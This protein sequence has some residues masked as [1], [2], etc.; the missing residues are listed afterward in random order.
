MVE[1]TIAAVI[2][3]EIPDTNGLSALERDR[4]EGDVL[5]FVVARVK[6]MA[7]F[8]RTPMIILIVFFELSSFMIYLKRFST[9][10]IP[11]RR[12]HITKT[13][14]WPLTPFNSLLKAIRSL[15]L[16]AYYDHPAVRKVID[17]DWPW[18]DLERMLSDR[19]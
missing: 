1:K 13:E 18:S 11:D 2:E 15:M 4:V 16:L 19:E 14:R 6:A 8:L 17:Y 12:V 5:N 10:L 3:A 7:F 9:L